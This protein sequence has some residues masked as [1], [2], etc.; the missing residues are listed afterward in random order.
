M[1][2]GSREK[3]GR[4]QDFQLGLI[5]VF[6][7]NFLFK[8]QFENIVPRLGKYQKQSH[9]H[10]RTLL[11]QFVRISSN[12]MSGHLFRGW[13]IRLEQYFYRT[14]NLFLHLNYRTPY[15]FGRIS[16]TSNDLQPIFYA[17]LIGKIFIPINSR[18]NI[19]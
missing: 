13:G 11:C 3:R 15:I 19:H 14:S 7:K 4:S 18:K 16:H 9:F 1:E 12:L 5:H 6:Y 8:I 10:F 17:P 2:K